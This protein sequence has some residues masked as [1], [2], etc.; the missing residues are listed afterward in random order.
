LQYFAEARGL[1]VAI[2]AAAQASSQLDVVYGPVQG[3]AIRDVVSATLIMYGAHEEE[4]MRSA[5]F[6]GGK[7]T[8]SDQSYL[9]N[10][11]DKATG[12]RFGSVFEPDELSPRNM[13]Q[14]RLLV[15]G[16]PGRM[17]NLVD[18]SDFVK[19]LDEARAVRRPGGGWAEKG[20]AGSTSNFH[21]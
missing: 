17:V 2:C 11:D 18:W 20:V 4:L 3:R 10:G 19:L 8:R 14:A 6:W 13:D 7:T 12:R 1:G 5:A 21:R 15:R 16:T 9:H